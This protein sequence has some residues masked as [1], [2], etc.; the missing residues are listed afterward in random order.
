[1]SVSLPRPFSHGGCCRHLRGNT[2]SL[3]IVTAGRC[4]HAFSDLEGA[5]AFRDGWDDRNPDGDAASIRS[6]RF[7]VS[8]EYQVRP[9]CRM[10]AVEFPSEIADGI[11]MRCVAMAISPHQLIAGVLLNSL[12]QPDA[13]AQKLATQVGKWESGKRRP[14]TRWPAPMQIEELS[15]RNPLFSEREAVA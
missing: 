15:V 5:Q 13:S 6:V 12:L 7:V 1:M 8:S 4:Q 3:W 9:Q 14:F 11:A 2:V 10:L